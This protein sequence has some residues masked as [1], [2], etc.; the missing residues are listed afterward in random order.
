[1]QINKILILA[2]NIFI[3]NKNKNNNKKLLIFLF[4]HYL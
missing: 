3:N 4:L 1:M 2:N